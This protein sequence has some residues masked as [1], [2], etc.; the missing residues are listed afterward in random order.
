[1]ISDNL[2]DTEYNIVQRQYIIIETGRSYDISVYLD[3]YITDNNAVCLWRAKST[4]IDILF[5]AY[6]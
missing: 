1:M 3:A 5:N 4:R 6:K 2:R